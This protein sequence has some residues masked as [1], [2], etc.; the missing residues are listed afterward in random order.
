MTPEL[1]NHPSFTVK[2]C[3][4]GAFLHYNQ[5]VMSD[6]IQDMIKDQV[7]LGKIGAQLPVN[8]QLIYLF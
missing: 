4:K 7:F 6:H 5:P 1:C 8:V 2:V 3:G